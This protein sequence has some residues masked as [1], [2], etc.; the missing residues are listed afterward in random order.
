MKNLLLLSLLL[1]HFA[2]LHAQ[3]PQPVLPLSR[4]QHPV[5]W[6]KE[7]ATAWKKIVDEDKHN[8]TGWYNLYYAKRLLSFHDT[9]D[10]RKPEQKKADMD[11]FL[12]DMETGIPG[13]YEMNLVK[14]MAGG[15]DMSKLAYLQKAEALGAGRTEHL[16]HMINVAEI[17]RKQKDKNSYAKRKYDAG[18]VS[19]GMMYYNYNMLA[20]LDSNAILLTVGDN[21]T[22]PAWVLQSLGIRADVHV[23]NL[24]LLLVDDYRVALFK[25]L[26]V[27]NIALNWDKD[28]ENAEMNFY[29]AVPAKLINNKKNLPVYISLTASYIAGLSVPNF[30]D[31]LYL[32]GLAYRYSD[33]PID[34]IALLKRNFESVYA[35]DYLDK[36]FY[37]DV[38][39]DLVK[40]LNTNYIVPMLRLYDHYTAAGDLAGRQRMKEKLLAV[41]KDS[42]EEEG[43][44]KHLAQQ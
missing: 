2:N 25:D 22:Y 26:G 28:Q 38:S 23:L 12:K 32:T 1:L 29:K 42:Q 4:E 5:A 36:A 40:Y 19:A 20:G 15:L 8:A 16:D 14:W 11:K 43:V 21:D 39:A 9:A 44:K 10:K 7:Q 35:L 33:K 6:Y 37:P 41:S 13:T 17:Q 27:E 18:D 34:N 31:K 3:K 24:S 30:E